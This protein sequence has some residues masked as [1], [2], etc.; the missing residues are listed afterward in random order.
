[1]EYILEKYSIF[2]NKTYDFSKCNKEPILIDKLIKEKLGED[3]F[4]NENKLVNSYLEMNYYEWLDFSW[5][6]QEKIYMRYPFL[7]NC[8]E[9]QLIYTLV[10][11]ANYFNKYG[12]SISLCLVKQL[13]SLLSLTNNELLLTNNKI[14]IFFIFINQQ[15]SDLNKQSILYLGGTLF[16]YSTFYKYVYKLRVDEINLTLMIHRLNKILIPNYLNEINIDFY[17]LFWIELY[18]NFMNKDFQELTED[19]LEIYIN[20]FNKMFIFQY[21]YPTLTN[22]QIENIIFKIIEYSNLND[23]YLDFLKH[24]NSTKINKYD[25]YLLMNDLRKD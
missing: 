18:D 14:L 23:F 3:I 12:I 19:K 9:E 15:K 13:A 25:S 5:F 21:F 20:D 1:M 8:S 24:I 4:Y 10:S 16:S 7:K 2:M 22:E 17:K 11:S 6:L